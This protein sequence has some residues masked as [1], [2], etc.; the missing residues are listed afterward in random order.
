VFF[1]QAEDGIRDFHVTGVQT[2]ALPIWMG[3][4]GCGGFFPVP[5]PLVA[6]RRRGGCQRLPKPGVEP[7]GW[8]ASARAEQAQVVVAE[9]AADEIGR[10]SCRAR[11]AVWVNGV[12][13]EERKRP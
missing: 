13:G 3:D 5:Q 1:F 9:P 2:C 6:R 12:T 4:P 11:V 8:L 10:A 7:G